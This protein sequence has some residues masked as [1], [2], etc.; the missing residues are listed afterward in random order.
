MP[1]GEPANGGAGRTG[2]PP[3][4]PALRSYY[5]PRL[6]QS[7]N[8]PLWS[9][10]R[11]RALLRQLGVGRFTV[12]LV[13]HPSLPWNRYVTKPIAAAARR[14]SGETRFSWRG[15]PIGYAPWREHGE[16]QVEIPIAL[17]FLHRT[18][19]GPKTILEVGNVLRSY[20]TLPRVVV[21]KYEQGDGILNL[22]VVDFQPPT[23]FDV[24][25]AISTLEHVGW[26]EDHVDLAKFRRALDHLWSC[27]APDGDILVTVPLGYHPEVDRVVLS[28]EWPAGDATIYLHHGVRGIWRIAPVEEVARSGPPMYP[29]GLHRAQAVAVWEAHRPPNPAT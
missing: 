12:R 6:D 3:S 19:K 14:L 27:V 24:V 21:D 13:A 29:Y 9:W 23:P 11:A 28:G 17:E 5:G 16:R 8:G 1:A 26:D 2:A 10:R 15:S 25:V 7:Y 4:L 20:A 18:A 22:D